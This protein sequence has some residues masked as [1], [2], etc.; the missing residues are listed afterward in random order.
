MAS[1]SHADNL[2]S[3]PASSPNTMLNHCWI[4]GKK[5]PCCFAQVTTIWLQIMPLSRSCYH[6]WSPSPVS[7]LLTT[8]KNIYIT[9]PLHKESNFMS[10]FFIRKQKLNFVRKEKNFVVPCDSLCWGLLRVIKN[11]RWFITFSRDMRYPCQ[12]RAFHRQTSDRCSTNYSLDSFH[13][14]ILP[15]S[16]PLTF[17]AI[18]QSCAELCCHNLL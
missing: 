15:M 6:F 18:C 10:N 13:K 1:Y 16:S 12:N 9:N 8:V 11:Y 7:I 5:P 3:R 4:N 14:T 17:T 2:S